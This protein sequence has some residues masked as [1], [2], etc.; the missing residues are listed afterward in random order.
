[1]QS[2]ISDTEEV[3]FGET[4]WPQRECFMYTRYLLL[5]LA[6]AGFTAR[7]ISQE[8]VIEPTN[9]R[10]QKSANHVSR[11]SAAESVPAQ[12]KE[13]KPSAKTSTG[14]RNAANKPAKKASL[15][16]VSVKSKVPV[17]THPAVSPAPESAKSAEPETKP[18]V[19]KVPA[20]PQWALTDT[21]DAH[22]LQIEIANALARDPKLAT[23]SIQV[24]VDDTSVTLDGQAAGI[25]ERL[26]AQRLAQSYAWN[27]KLVEKIE[28]E[29][30]VSAAK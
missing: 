18:S 7:A 1:V 22:S 15:K 4:G 6:L 10:A 14:E 2:G 5:I 24:H 16:Q 13:P 30:R 23:S 11:P 3:W 20:R 28:V 8:I 17:E 26:Q 25:E 19:I 27:R 12:V 29:H 9:G 21:R